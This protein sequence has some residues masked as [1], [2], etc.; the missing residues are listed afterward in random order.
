MQELSLKCGIPLGVESRTRVCFSFTLDS[1][2]F[3]MYVL[4]LGTRTG[5][6]EVV[7]RKSEWMLVCNQQTLENVRAG[8]PRLE[9]KYLLS[10]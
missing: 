5:G 7:Q 4:Y 6:L 2:V 10:T 1:F 3:P 9:R 8:L